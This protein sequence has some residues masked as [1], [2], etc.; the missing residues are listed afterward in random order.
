MS[1]ILSL[2]WSFDYLIVKVLMKQISLNSIRV[3]LEVYVIK[4]PTALAVGMS[5]S[6]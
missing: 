4:N 6:I 1:L 5:D 3:I 2:M